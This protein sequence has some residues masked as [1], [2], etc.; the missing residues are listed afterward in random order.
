LKIAPSYAIIGFRGFTPLEILVN[1][2]YLLAGGLLVYFLCNINFAI[3]FTKRFKHQ[4]IRQLGSKNPGTTNVVRNFGLKLGVLTFVCDLSKGVI[5]AL[6]G[7]YA[8]FA[9]TQ[10]LPTAVF[11]GYFFGACAVLGHI[12]PVFLKFKGGKGIATSLGLFLTLHPL[13]TLATLFLAVIIILTTDKVS[14]FA[15]VHI[16]VQAAYTAVRV[17]T[18]ASLARYAA[19][20]SFIAVFI[21]WL[22]I[23]IAHRQN[24]VRLIKGEEKGI[25]IKKLVFKEKKARKGDSPHKEETTAE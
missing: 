23:I 21:I 22:V 25:G 8:L 16:T 5:A 4:D 19:L 18:D 17:F 6:L 15:L 1:W 24:I 9:L 11:G 7:R 12:H 13:F 2:H 20:A 3:I 14:I 10:S